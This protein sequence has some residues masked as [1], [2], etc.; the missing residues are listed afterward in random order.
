[1]EGAL[2]CRRGEGEVDDDFEAGGDAVAA[3]DG[4]AAG[5]DTAAGD[6]E[7]ESDTAAARGAH[8]VEPVEGGENRFEIGFRETRT[9]ILHDEAE[10]VHMR[11]AEDADGTVGASVG[12]GVANEIADGADEEFAVGADGEAG[13]DFRGD[14]A[15]GFF[16]RQDLGDD[17]G[18]IEGFE[19]RGASRAAGE[20]E[21]IA[22][23]GGH[24]G[25]IP[26]EALDV[27]LF[28]RGE[29]LG[30]DARA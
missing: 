7:A 9:R 16:L 18:R 26:L 10:P 22:D 11:G 4:A 3:V 12:K 17:G 8:V 25:D 2:L 30:E 29:A 13:T 19:N 1:M 6:R 20:R 23:K 28:G 15:R 27:G 24:V 5:F 21:E 14:A